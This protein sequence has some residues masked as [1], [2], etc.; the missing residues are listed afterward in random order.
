MKLFHEVA[1]APVG[2]EG[3]LP[4]SDS[5]ASWALLSTLRVELLPYGSRN[6]SGH[7]A[8]T[9]LLLQSF[10]PSISQHFGFLFL[11]Y[12]FHHSYQTRV[13]N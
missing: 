13:S 10:S 9:I 5:G 11:H 8:N 6:G 7:V 4:P 1:P 12:F 3:G 2:G